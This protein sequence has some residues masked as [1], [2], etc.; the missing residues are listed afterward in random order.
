MNYLENAQVA[1]QAL[2]DTYYVKGTFKGSCFWDRAEL[3]ELIADACENIS[4]DYQEQLQEM[5]NTSKVISTED[6]SRNPYFDDI[7]WMCIAYERASIIL[8]KPHYL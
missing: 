1:L 3:M 7:L 8:N 4:S 5:I 6:W 2:N